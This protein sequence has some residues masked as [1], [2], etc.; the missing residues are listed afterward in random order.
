ML[1]IHPLL[2]CDKI[3]S[4]LL[5][6]FSIIRNG[7]P[8]T[9]VGSFPSYSISPI[10]IKTSSL[11]FFDER[12]LF[13]LGSKWDRRSVFFSFI[14][15]YTFNPQKL[16]YCIEQSLIV[17]CN[18]L[19]VLC[20]GISS[21]LHCFLKDAHKFWLN[22]HRHKVVRNSKQY[23]YIKNN[24]L[25]SMHCFFIDRLLCELQIKATVVNQSELNELNESKRNCQ[26]IMNTCQKCTGFTLPIFY[27]RKKDFFGVCTGVSKPGE[28]CEN[29]R[30]DATLRSLAYTDLLLS[31]SKGL[32]QV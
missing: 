29:S 7:F 13:I 32:L 1:G 9:R 31:S 26:S 12:D 30:A 19:L 25:D 27:K 3:K 15:S 11:T 18:Q 28:V 24:V 20:S 10:L 6:L 17:H 4:L 22:F 14:F 23:F 2:N 16:S 8:K 21:I 5:F